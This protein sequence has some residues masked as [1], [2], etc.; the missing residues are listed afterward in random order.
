[1]AVIEQRTQ[2]I[3]LECERQEESCLYTSTALY[4]WVKEIR[5]GRVIFIVIPIIC[6]SFAT[7]RLF[8][9]DPAFDWWIAIAAMIS[10]LFPAIF[11][12]LDLDVSLQSVTSS[13]QRF[14]TLQDRFRQA[15]RITSTKP[16]DEFQRAFDTLMDEMDSARSASPA[17]PKRHFTAAQ[18]KIASGDYKFAADAEKGQ[19]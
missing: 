2:E 12:A 17:V 10:G 5:I 6:S 4:E 11:K 14:K 19:A 7:S 8:V 15:A 9:R 18:K 1:M 13:A 16:V 3:R